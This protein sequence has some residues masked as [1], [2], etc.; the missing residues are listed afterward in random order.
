[1]RL[2]GGVRRL[3]ELLD[4]PQAPVPV[5]RHPRHRVGGRVDRG[6]L[7]GELDLAPVPLATDESRPFE[8]DQVLGD[9]L[10]GDR[11]V[12]GKRGCTRL[13]TR[14]Q[15]VQEPPARGASRRR[16]TLSR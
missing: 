6:G 15:R 8:D 13:P 2:P 9:R 1:L 14:Q 7:D 10:A 3:G 16:A 12:G 11:Q 4:T 5:R